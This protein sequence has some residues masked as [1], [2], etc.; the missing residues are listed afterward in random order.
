MLLGELAEATAVDFETTFRNA[1]A[2]L[3]TLSISVDSEGQVHNF[4]KIAQHILELDNKIYSVSLLPQGVIKYISPSKGR[5]KLTNFNI[6]GDSSINTSYE[7]R[8]TKITKQIRLSGPFV[9]IQGDTVCALRLPIFLNNEFWGFSAITYKLTDLLD[10]AGLGK[11][12]DFHNIGYA[13]SFI[14]PSLQKPSFFYPSKNNKIPKDFA[15]YDVAMSSW[16]VYAYS[17]K[18]YFGTF[19]FWPLFLCL[20]VG[21]LVGFLI[22]LVLARPEQLRDFIDTQVKALDTSEARFKII[23]ENAPVGIAIIDHKTAFLS[24]VNKRFCK[25]AGYSKEFLLSGLGLGTIIPGDVYIDA[26]DEFQEILL[27]KRAELFREYKHIRQNGSMAW[28]N[29]TI[30][31]I[32]TDGIIGDHSIVIVEDVTESKLNQEAIEDSQLRFKKLFEESPIPKWEEDFSEVI[33]HLEELALIGKPKKEVSAFFDEHPQEVQNCVSKLKII[34]ANKAVLSLHKVDDKEELY[35]NIEKYMVTEKFMESS[36]QILISLCNHEES[37]TVESQ[38]RTSTGEIRDIITKWHVTSGKGEKY[39][40]VIVASLDITDIKNA[41][42]ALSEANSRLETIIDTIDGIVWTADPKDLKINFISGKVKEIT[43]FDKEDVLGKELFKNKG[44]IVFVEQEAVRKNFTKHIKNFTPHTIEYRTITKDGHIKWFRDSISFIKDNDDTVSILGIMVDITTLKEAQHKLEE[45]NA[46]LELILNNIDGVV[47]T[48]D[49]QTFDYTFISDKAEELTGYK[50]EEWISKPAFCNKI[51]HADDIM[52]QMPECRANVE[53]GIAHNL[54]YKI[55]TKE[56][57]LKWVSESIDFIR[58]DKGRIDSIVGIMF[59]IT[60]LRESE[61]KLKKSLSTLSEQNKRLMNF[62]YIVSHNLH[63]HSSNIQSLSELIVDSNDHTER[64]ELTGHL[65]GVAN[66]LNNTMEGLNEVVNIQA[67]TEIAK[68]NLPLHTYI[69]K[70]CTVLRDRIEATNATV[71]NNVP[72]NA[73]V[74]F[75]N[76]YLESILLNFISNGIKYSSSERKPVITLSFFEDSKNKILSISDNGIGIDL[77]K[78][79]KKLFG[80]FKTFS[81]NPESKGIGLYIS[82]HQME[83]MGGKITV[84]S[85]IDKGTT[86]NIYFD[87]NGID[88]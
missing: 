85:A 25:I 86:F 74:F 61:E 35:N 83:V 5:E 49:P 77:E 68:T 14:D 16:Q 27:N 57:T 53:K 6:L 76:S 30:A 63:S 19:S 48:A 88:R 52:T 15:V 84:E 11:N 37:S 67:N 2:N 7:A 78:N 22:L 64:Q 32:K 81:H 40:H 60:K 10:N 17:K 65:M 75:N 51:M 69:E 28:V 9:N 24:D 71:H 29:V 56:G 31:P 50:Q 47:W 58:D 55:N 79:G 36:K 20:L 87:R 12:K 80:L 3:L 33:T 34:N 82:K 44:N 4:N 8:L 43:G 46:Q 70:T 42:S 73:K 72:R 21:S 39:N 1:A 45:S 62:S 26:F 13:I 54:Q 59:D 66:L 18:P 38:A 41:Q 23:F